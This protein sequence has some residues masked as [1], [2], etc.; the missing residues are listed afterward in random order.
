MLVRNNLKVNIMKIF[1]QSRDK[2]RAFKANST[3]QANKQVKDLGK[4]SAKRW[5]IQ[6]SKPSK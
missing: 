3:N 6:L 1:F 5:A 2:A 4:E